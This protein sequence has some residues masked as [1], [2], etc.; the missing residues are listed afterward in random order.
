MLD[1]SEMSTGRRITFVIVLS[2]IFV[3]VAVP[4]KVLNLIPGIT[5][6]RPV[7]CL[8]MIFG[9]MFGIYGAL[10]C[11]IGNIIA[12]I[13]GGTLTVSSWAGFVSNF[14]GT[15]LAYLMW[16]GII[17]ERPR[18][19]NLKQA[20][21]FTLVSAAIGMVIAGIVTFGVEL[22]Y[23]EVDGIALFVQIFLNTLGFSV[24]LGM[25]LV[26]MLEEVYGV[27]GCVPKKYQEEK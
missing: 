3:L 15:Y 8:N 19:R 22:S 17:K 2:I 20:A 11:A 24:I 10:G 1:T 6:I 23:P 25:P 4:F 18:I 13:L 9:V 26:I 14:A 16:Y 12:D 27:K 7:D 21:A 5:E